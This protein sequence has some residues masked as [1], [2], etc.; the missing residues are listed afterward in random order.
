MWFMI[1]LAIILACLCAYLAY[2]AWER[3]EDRVHAYLLGGAAIAGT[4][5][6]FIVAALAIILVTDLSYA[7]AKIF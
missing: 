5:A 6:V 1:W 2:L 3:D 7:Q 4:M